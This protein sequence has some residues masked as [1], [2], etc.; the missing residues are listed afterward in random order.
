MQP[1]ISIITLGVAD[2][3]RSTSFYRDGLGLPTNFKDG[4]GIAFFQLSGTWLALY[5]LNALAEDAC[6]PS[7]RNQ[8]GGITLAH[9]VSNKMEVDQVIAQAFASGAKIL[10]PAT[11]TFWGGYSGYFADLDSYPWEVAWNPFF[12]L[13]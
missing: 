13:E 7:E 4:E 8:F 10:K 12:H 5:P 6:L 11:D 9:N 3:E 1:H 2:L